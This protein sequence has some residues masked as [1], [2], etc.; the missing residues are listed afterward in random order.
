MTAFPVNQLPVY[1]INLSA[2][3]TGDSS[4]N[5]QFQRLGIVADRVDAVTI[6]DVGEDRMLP[7]ADLDNP[8]AMTRVEVA[9]VMSHEKAWRTTA[10]T[11]AAPMP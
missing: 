1:Y 10:R 8:W 9:C 6:A 3:L 11:E 2:R 5:E 7:H 4:S